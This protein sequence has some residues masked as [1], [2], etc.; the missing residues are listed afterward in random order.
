MLARA[1]TV[2]A[3]KSDT[4]QEPAARTCKL[5][6]WLHGWR[7]SGLKHR[8]SCPTGSTAS[9]LVGPPA[10]QRAL[11]LLSLRRISKIK[12]FLHVSRKSENKI[13][14]S[15]SRRPEQKMRYSRIVCL[16]HGSWP[17]LA[18]K[19]NCQRA[20]RE[21]ACAGEVQ[22]GGEIELQLRNIVRLV[23][24]RRSIPASPLLAEP[25]ASLD[26]II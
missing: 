23:A 18:R 12:I 19:Q 16:V 7:R 8:R 5:Q 17:H 6:S 14:T 13:S 24:G 11:L 22:F 10:L 25:Y 20:E 9:Q 3:L 21:R 2:R 15:T 4:P 1:L 26:L